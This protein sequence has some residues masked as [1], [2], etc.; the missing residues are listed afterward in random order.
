MQFGANMTDDKAG[1]DAVDGRKGIISGCWRR[2]RY[3]EAET[4][5]AQQI[6][7]SHH[8]LIVLSV[9]HSAKKEGAGAARKV[10]IG[11]RASGVGYSTIGG[12]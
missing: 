10:L 11:R 1:A 3:V 8:W 5:V 2:G 6:G 7:A 9:A 12:F 4:D